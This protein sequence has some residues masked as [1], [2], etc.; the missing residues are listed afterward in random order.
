MAGDRR[1]SSP[2]TPPLANPTMGILANSSTGES[3][4]AT[5]RCWSHPIDGHHQTRSPPSDTTPSRI[6]R[7]ATALRQNTG[8]DSA[9]PRRERRRRSPCPRK[10]E[11]PV[12]P[13]AAGIR[14]PSGYSS[15]GTSPGLVDQEE[16]EE[17]GG[18]SWAGM[19]RQRSFAPETNPLK[20]RI[21]LST[22]LHRGT[23]SIPRSSHQ[24]VA[25]CRFPDVTAARSSSRF[26]RPG[27]GLASRSSPSTPN[28]SASLSFFRNQLAGAKGKRSTGRLLHF[29][30][31][32]FMSLP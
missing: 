29:E 19:R 1:S 25:A 10:R 2:L 21:H 5:A 8:V 28:P 23:A 16:G 24:S 27:P 30:M 26:G 15:K 17:V 11:N 18:A 12:H 14:R 13:A 20:Y 4:A 6:R 31:C 32:A 22:G 3:N 7:R 9:I